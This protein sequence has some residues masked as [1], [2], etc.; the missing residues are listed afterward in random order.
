LPA[1]PFSGQPFRYRVSAGETIPWNKW[2]DDESA[3]RTLAPGTGIVWSVGPDLRDDGGM[4]HQ[5][6]GWVLR[7]PPRDMDMLF[8]VPGDAAR[9]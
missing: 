2:S 9:R 8:L 3:S 6:R 1:D 5:A 7:L 4:A